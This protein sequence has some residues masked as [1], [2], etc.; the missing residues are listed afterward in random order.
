MSISAADRRLVWQRANGACEYCRTFEAWEPFF[1]YHIEHVVARQH[2]GVDSL[3]NLA[4][5]CHHC[6]LHKGPNLSSIDHA[7]GALTPLFHP[8]TQNWNDH[9]GMENGQ[10]RGLSAAGRA[11]VFLLQMNAVHRVELRLACVSDET[12]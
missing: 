1:T 5:A 10:V 3:E 2:G 7:T 4:L 9:F 11:T 12:A 6:N 8:R